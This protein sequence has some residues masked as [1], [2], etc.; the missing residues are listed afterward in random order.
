MLLNNPKQ[1]DMEKETNNSFNP[2]DYKFQG[3]SDE[4]F[5]S[6]YEDEVEADLYRKLIDLSYEARSYLCEMEDE[7]AIYEKQKGK[8]DKTKKLH[9]IIKALIN[10]LE[11]LPC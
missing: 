9:K 8:S 3:M 5:N 10:K 11:V 2:Y 1:V 7:V 6:F 4:E